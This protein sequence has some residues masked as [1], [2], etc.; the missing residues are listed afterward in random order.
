MAWKRNV[1]VVANVTAM[2]TDLLDALER[3]AAREP[4]AF[5][6]VVPATPSGGGRAAAAENLAAA[7]EQLR[8]AQLEADG[9]VGDGNPVTAV[10]DEWDPGRYD[11]VIVSTLPIR[12]SKWL[13][14]GLPERIAKLTGAPVTHVVSEPPRPAPET[15]AAPEHEKHGLITP[16]YGVGVHAESHRAST[17]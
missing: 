8:A 5:T 1:L 14:A 2:S 12:V 15:V 3:R 10:M 13:H 4:T 11:E 17:R 9:H 16:F 6:L 7:L